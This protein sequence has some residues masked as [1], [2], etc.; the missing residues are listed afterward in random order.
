[1]NI[2]QLLNV[3]LFGGGLWQPHLDKLMGKE[4]KYSEVK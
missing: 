3:K 2:C 1:M 4:E